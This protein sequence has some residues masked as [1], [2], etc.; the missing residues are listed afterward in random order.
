MSISS[1]MKKAVLHLLVSLL[2]LS[3]NTNIFATT[4]QFDSGEESSLYTS[5]I[6]SVSQNESEVY[7]ENMSGSAIAI[8][9][10]WDGED[11][12]GAGKGKD[13]FLHSNVLPKM[14]IN[15]PLNEHTSVQ[16]WA[17]DSA[18]KK[19]DSCSHSLSN[20][21]VLEGQPLYLGPVLSVHQTE[22]EIVV[23]NISVST[24]SIRI[25]WNNADPGGIGNGEGSFLNNNVSPNMRLRQPLKDYESVQ[26]WAWNKNGKV[27]DSCNNLLKNEDEL[28]GQKLYVGNIFSVSQTETKILV[29]NLSTSPVSIRISWD[30]QDQNAMGKGEDSTMHSYVT[31]NMVIKQEIKEHFSVQVWAWGASGELADFCSVQIIPEL[32]E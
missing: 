20:P 18:G 28:Q 7:V 27:V 23:E 16:I 1:T 25:S 32:N 17:W 13:S 5:G 11:P 12:D 8:R 19:I 15:R 14:R 31:Q 2:F 26:I 21:R 10:S 30:D 6:L 22:T 9:V 29:E 3:V 24:V 4:P